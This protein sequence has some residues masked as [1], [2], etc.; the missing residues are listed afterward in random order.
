MGFL[1]DIRRVRRFYGTLELKI[2]ADREEVRGIFVLG[3][4]AT[5]L[6]AREL[7]SYK[8]LGLPIQF[9]LTDLLYGWGAYTFLMVM[10][11]SSDWLGERIAKACYV[12]AWW[13]F[14]TSLIGSMCLVFVGE[15]GFYSAFFTTFPYETWIILIVGSSPSIL[16]GCLVGLWAIHQLRSGGNIGGLRRRQ[17]KAEAK[18]SKQVEQQK[19]KISTNPEAESKKNQTDSEQ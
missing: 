9:Y 18:Q 16:A 10:G 15:L 12:S 4:I 7:L 2:D 3:V 19:D 13:V 11:V 8:L 1:N 5:I 17:T 14:V 6:T